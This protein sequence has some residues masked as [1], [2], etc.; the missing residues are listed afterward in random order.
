MDEHQAIALLKSGKLNGLEYLVQVY[1]VQAV[2]T[3][4]MIV[5]DRSLAEEVVQTAFLTAADK[6]HQFDAQRP[7]GPWFLRIVVNASLLT[8]KR[9]SRHIPLQED[10][11]QPV[12]DW[13]VDPAQ[14][15]QEL[16]ETAETR[17]EVLASLQKLAP[18][19]RAAL[20]M[21]YYL[22]MTDQEISFELRQ[23]LST[24]KWSLHS[25]K[26]RLKTLLR[27]VFYNH[28]NV[29]TNAPDRKH[30]SIEHERK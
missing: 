22:D 1:Q 17:R 15:L 28:Q 29:P 12:P 14:S 9:R 21:R 6:I 18:K 3:A 5:N 10:E 16:V 20:V 19:Q 23:P 8:C 4:Y 11:A 24:T 13:L 30:R 7:F 27:A 26:E 2:Q 25:A